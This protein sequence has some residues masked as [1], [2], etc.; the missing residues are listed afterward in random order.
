MNTDP[1]LEKLR[2]I[3]ARVT[4]VDVRMSALESGYALDAEQVDAF[5]KA[6]IANRPAR[7]DDFLS[8]EEIR[9]VAM[10]HTKALNRGVELDALDYALAAGCGVFSGLL[11]VLF[12]RSPATESAAGTAGSVSDKLFDNL[13]V[14]IAQNVEAPD[15]KTWSPQGSGNV[16]ASA[17]GHLEK[18]KVGYDQAT[19]K[20]MGGSVKHIK[21][22]NHHAKSLAHY[23]DI[24][25]LIASICNQFTDTSSF[26]D[27]KR[28]EI[29]VVPGTGNGIELRGNSLTAKVFAGTINWLMHCISDVAGSSGS[30]GRGTG[31]PIPFTEFFQLCN[32]GR[33]P[34]DKG[35]WQ[36][37]ATVMTEVYEQGYDLRHG[38][39][40]SFPV[41][42]NDLLLRA[43]YSFK[44]HF[45]NGAAWKGSLPKKDSPELQRMVTIGVGSMCLVDLGHAAAASWGNWIKFFSELNLIAWARFGLQGVKELD[46]MANRETRNLL[47]TSEEISDDWNRLLERSQALL[48]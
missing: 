1:Y 8:K 2:A 33:F 9:A 24:F 47:A 40:A 32:H 31:L 35:Q 41:I 10:R 20:A 21:M 27:S 4:A 13:V 18:Y 14:R 45:V 48:K 37:F 46:L 34:N 15:G 7:Y 39:A 44:Q 5:V 43:I 25:G 38:V 12:V 11:D 26:F 6:Q 17:I 36:S 23:P 42:I 30:K 28:G 16:V 22:K 3:Q 29:I 19:T